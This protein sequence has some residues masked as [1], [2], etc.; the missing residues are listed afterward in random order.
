MDTP[1]DTHASFI[2]ASHMTPMPVHFFV[3]KRNDRALDSTQQSF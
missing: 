1:L 3:N 2:D